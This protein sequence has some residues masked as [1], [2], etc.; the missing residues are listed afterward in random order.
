M[1]AG[2]SSPIRRLTGSNKSGC[3]R[4]RTL[5][6][7][8]AAP[9]LKVADEINRTAAGSEILPPQPPSPPPPTL[10]NEQQDYITAK[11]RLRLTLASF[12]PRNEPRLPVGSFSPSLPPSSFSPPPPPHS[13]CQDA[14]HLY[15]PRWAATCQK[16]GHRGSQFTGY[17]CRLTRPFTR[18]GLFPNS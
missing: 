7:E 4:R 8:G 6:S 13:R 11:P 12:S 16:G 2:P 10:P 5:M 9:L 14:T 3:G 15:F 1:A 17:V 18:N